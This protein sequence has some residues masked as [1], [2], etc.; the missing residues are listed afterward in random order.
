MG[1]TLRL[2]QGHSRHQSEIKTGLS[3]LKEAG[4]L[5]LMLSAW[6]WSHLPHGSV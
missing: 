6:V 5:R 2:E 4:T 3:T 1:V